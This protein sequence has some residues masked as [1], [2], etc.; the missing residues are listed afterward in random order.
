MFWMP[1]ASG[2][3]RVPTCGKKITDDAVLAFNLSTAYSAVKDLPEPGMPTSILSA[4]YPAERF[5]TVG[6]DTERVSQP[7]TWRGTSPSGWARTPS[8]SQPPTRR[9]RATGAT[10]C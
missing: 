6:L 2:P 1:L 7:P 4:A 8:I 9:G 10:T 3:L 5:H